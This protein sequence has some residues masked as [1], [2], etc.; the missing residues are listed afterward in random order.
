[1]EEIYG[2][3]TAFS[4]TLAISITTQ[5]IK[6]KMGVDDWRAMALTLATSLFWAGGFNVFT[7]ALAWRDAGYVVEVLDIAWLVFQS[8]FYVMM[9]YFS[10][11]GL[12]KTVT[13]MRNGHG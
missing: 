6:T 12:Y 9:A 11:L 10:A 13:A 5:F 7:T 1:M 4:V 3:I 2:P 8:L